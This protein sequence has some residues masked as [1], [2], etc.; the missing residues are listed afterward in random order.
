MI[1]SEDAPHTYEYKNYF[2]ILPAIN[3]WSSDINRINEGKLVSPSFNY[4]SNTNT[5]WMKKDELKSW[6]K[7]NMKS[8]NLI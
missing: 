1:V 5:D 8:I 3:N 6:I 4:S 2:K 7:T